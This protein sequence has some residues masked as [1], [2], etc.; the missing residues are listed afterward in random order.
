MGGIAHR[1]DSGLA[2]D[3]APEAR[4]GI[5]HGRVRELEL[6]AYRVRVDYDCVVR[7]E[8]R[9]GGSADGEGLAALQAEKHVLGGELAAVVE[10]HVLAELHLEGKVVDE[11]PLRGQARLDIARLVLVDKLVEDVQLHR[12]PADPV[13][14]L[15]IERRRLLPESH[16]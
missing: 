12:A 2:H 1:R 6:E 4:E 16:L 15:G 14:S 13:G 9:V 10:G 8:E 5:E 7:I 3:V 11:L